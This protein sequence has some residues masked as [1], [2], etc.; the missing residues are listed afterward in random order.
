MSKVLDDFYIVFIDEVGFMIEPLIIKTWARRGHRPVIKIAENHHYRISV[1]GAIAI[2][3]KT[4]N[5]GFFFHL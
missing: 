2:N 4:Q 1:I 3:M 5:Y